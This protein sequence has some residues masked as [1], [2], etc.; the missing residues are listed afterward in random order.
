MAGCTAAEASSTS[1]LINQ[2]SQMLAPKIAEVKWT[3][4]GLQDVCRGQASGDW[5]SRDKQA[6]GFRK[7]GPDKCLEST[8]DFSVQGPKDGQQNICPVFCILLESTG[9]DLERTLLKDLPKRLLIKIL[10]VSILFCCC[11]I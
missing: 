2:T 8:L 6:S 11:K 7:Y 10:I 9:A 3:L 5:L 1:D 4:V